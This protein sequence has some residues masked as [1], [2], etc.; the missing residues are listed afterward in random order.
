MLSRPEHSQQLTHCQQDLATG[1]GGSMLLAC[2]PSRGGLLCYLLDAVLATTH[3]ESVLLGLGQLL[4]SR[5]WPGCPSIGQSWRRFC[6]VS[7][8][9]LH[10]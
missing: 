2:D 8:S 10:L 1:A 7:P 3:M 9:L 5:S 6:P 4:L